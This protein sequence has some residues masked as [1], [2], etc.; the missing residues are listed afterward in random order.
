MN[1]SA[2]ARAH[3]FQYVIWDVDGDDMVFVVREAY[4]NTKTYHDGGAVT[5]YRLADYQKLVKERYPQEEFWKNP[6]RKK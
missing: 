3:G 2:S 5:L 6:S 1:A 4:G